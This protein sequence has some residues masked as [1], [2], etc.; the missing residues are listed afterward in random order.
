MT[1]SIPENTPAL[2]MDHFPRPA[3]QGHKYH[4]GF[5][6]ILGAPELTGATRLAA[7]AC[8]RVGCGLVTVVAQARSDIYRATL[9]PD[10]MVQSGV[11]QKATV[12]LG[13]PGGITQPQMQTLWEA[14]HLHA[15]VFDAGAIP[16]AQDMQRFDGRCILTPHT[17]EFERAFGPVGA[18]ADAAAR[19]LAARSGATV[20]LKSDR[21]VI[22]SADGRAL[23]NTHTSP[24][25][26]KAGTGDVLAGLIA[27]L[28][29]QGMPH[30]EACCAAVWLH[31][32]AGRLIG[33]GLIAGDIPEALPAILRALL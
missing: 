10:I 11:P 25:L 12:L 31:G 29:A 32:E 17:G 2:W 30:F 28:V 8:S 14:D 6:A 1:E 9:P 18:Q 20:V 26:A 21:T 16:A 3:A 23:R 15:R 4:R 19:Q 24:Y 13:G 5:A 7:A 33:P 22:A 27:G